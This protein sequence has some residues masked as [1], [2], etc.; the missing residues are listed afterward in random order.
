MRWLTR[1]LGKSSSSARPTPSRPRFRL[2]LENLEER[3]VPSTMSSIAQ[4]FNPTAIPAG[5]SVWFNAVFQANNLPPGAT[6]TLHVVNQSISFTANGTSYNVAVPNGVIV[7]TPGATS[8]AASYDPSDN[9]WDVSAPTGG[10]PAGPGNVFMSGAVLTVPNGLPGGIQNVTW[11]AGFWSDTNNI[12][13]SWKWAAAVYNSF[14]TN[15]NALGVKPVDNNN[16]SIYKNGDHAGT[17]ETYKGSV[18]AGATGGGGNNFTGNY[19]PPPGPGQPASGQNMTPQFGDGASLYPYVSSN[20]LTSIAFNESGVLVGSKLDTTNG[21]FDLWYSD[22]HA[23]ALGVGTVVVKTSTGITTTNYPIASLN[24]DPGSATYPALGTTA[25]SGDQAGTDVSGR[26]MAPSLFITDTTNN[27]ESASGDWQWGGSAYAPSAVFGA[28]KPFTRTVDYTT[29]TPTITVTPPADP[30]ANG[31]N[32]GTGADAPPAGTSNAGYGA[33]VRWSLSDLTN[34]GV[35]VAGHTYR[36]Y[37]MVHDGDQNKAGGDAGQAAYN[38]Y[39]PGPPAPTTAV[40]SGKVFD[41]AG[42]PVVG[43][44]ITLSGTDATGQA[45]SRQTWTNGSGVYSFSNVAAGSNYTITEDVTTLPAGDSATGSFAGTVGGTTDGSS[46]TT[47]TIVGINLNGG[48]NGINYN[49]TVFN[50]AD[51]A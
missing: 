46:G 43:V 6:V 29:A 39:Y 13:V 4:N 37:V 9:D 45:F 49:F 7:L 12:T 5:D 41:E 10:G 1:L 20:P 34:Q 25:T 31:W 27:P 50:P 28:W 15:Y 3:T 32:L 51:A 40:I 44:G 19:P 24:S 14:S 17:P 18:V 33:E 21:Y 26:P 23:L 35:L 2:E 36:F 22:E 11:S 38:Y 48:D 42:V 30:A 47:S 8:A 16:L